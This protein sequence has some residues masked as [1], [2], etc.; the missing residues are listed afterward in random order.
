MAYTIV[1][2]HVV[3]YREK[4][5]LRRLSASPV[6]PETLLSAVLAVKVA[7]TVIGAVL[8]L[9]VGGLALGLS[10]PQHPIGFAVVFVLGTLALLSLGLLIA[11]QA[12]TVGAATAIGMLLFFPSMF[13]G[14]IY[15]PSEQ[16][17]GA[18]RRIG[19]ITP[20]G[21]LLQALRDSWVGGGPQPL[22]LAV[23]AM[24]TVVFGVLAARTFRW[25]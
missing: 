5:V 20:L 1:P 7:A 2:Q 23:L 12:R 25:E 14:G 22:H 9:G 17:P 11:A 16:L 10:V 4:D 24:A 19:E 6:R 15:V 21:A 18:L 3:A 8:V 13:L